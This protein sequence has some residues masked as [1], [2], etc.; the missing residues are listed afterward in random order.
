MHVLFISIKKRRANHIKQ[1]WKYTV[2]LCILA[3]SYWDDAM[4]I[5]QFRGVFADVRL[6][7]LHSLLW[8]SEME[9]TR[10]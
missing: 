1:E 8:R 6:D 3:H 2:G 10:T 5:N 7:C 9:C 4:V